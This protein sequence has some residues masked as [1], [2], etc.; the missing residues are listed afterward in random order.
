MP[1]E[2]RMVFGGLV[3]WTFPRAGEAVALAVRASSQH[4]HHRHLAALAYPAD[5]VKQFKPGDPEWDQNAVPP[6][7]LVTDEVGKLFARRLLVDE[8][9]SLT[10]NFKPGAASQD[11]VDNTTSGNMSLLNL[12]DL[13]P[14]AQDVDPACFTELSR[15]PAIA[16][17][18]TRFGVLEAEK[19]TETEGPWEYTPRGGQRTV[20][21][22]FVEATRLVLSDLVSLDVYSSKM[23][24]GEPLLRLM[25]TDRLE[26]SFTVEPEFGSV[27]R[28]PH[29]PHFEMNYGVVR[30]PGGQ[31]PAGTLVRPTKPQNYTIQGRICPGAKYA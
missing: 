9:L 8:A 12:R 18:S 3:V 28:L 25:A 14:S 29:P 6:D 27:D 2:L 22:G 17:L 24:G 10:P 31:R 23:A 26:V 13:E 5:S 19:T 1:F 16:S 11:F 21:E 20:I 15:S 30:W 7:P 4:P